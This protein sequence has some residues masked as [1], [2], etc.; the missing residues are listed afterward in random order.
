MASRFQDFIFKIGQLTAQNFQAL[1][2][3]TLSWFLSQAM[4]V[5]QETVSRQ[6]HIDPAEVIKEGFMG[7]G[8]PQRF[9]IGKMVLFKYDPKWKNTLEYYDIYPLIFPI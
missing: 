9:E 4:A 8:T 6:P 1:R 7:L 5:R 3:R 2:N